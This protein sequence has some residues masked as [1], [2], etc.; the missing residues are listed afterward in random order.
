MDGGVVACV[1]FR[2]SWVLNTVC[3]HELYY[4]VARTAKCGRALAKSQMHIEH[5]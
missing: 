4:S 1:V 3:L 5:A 2:Q